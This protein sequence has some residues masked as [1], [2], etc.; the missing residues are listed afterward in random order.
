MMPNKKNIITIGVVAVLLTGFALISEA[1]PKK[2]T[3]SPN[4][5]IEKVDKQSSPTL[6][7]K[8]T[9]KKK[10]TPMLTRFP[11]LKKPE[12]KGFCCAE[13]TFYS[14]ITKT[15]CERKRGS[16]YADTEYPLK[17][18]CGWC[19]R[20]GQA[21]SVRSSSEKNKLCGDPKILY[22]SQG[23]A[24]KNCG[25]CC[26]GLRVSAVTSRSQCD[27]KR[28][29]LEKEAAEKQCKPKPVTGVCNYKDR[30]IKKISKNR[31]EKLGGKFYKRF[32]LAQNAFVETRKRIRKTDNQEK[33]VW[34]CK[35]GEVSLIAKIDCVG[36]KEKPLD[37]KFFKT[38]AEANKNCNK[39]GQR[40]RTLMGKKPPSLR[41]PDL[42]IMKISVDR[43][44]FMTV[45]VRNIG[46]RILD[47]DQHARSTI[48]L[49]AG[50]DYISRKTQLTDID[51]HGELI[52]AGG[53]ITATT[54]LRIT[55]RNQPALVWVDTN[56]Q[57][58]EPDEI[59]NGDNGPLTCKIP[60]IWCCAKQQLGLLGGKNQVGKMT[61]EECQKLGGKDMP[62]KRQ[63][64]LRVG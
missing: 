52:D 44:C 47:S 10:K 15:E 23:E 64:N 61:K 16:R 27:S 25:W 33:R 1:A 60:L 51:P 22:S 14:Q 41:P 29:H 43:R 55:Q 12:E 24:E 31:C 28:F 42:K 58:I 63:P 45:R 6:S 34:C 26:R 48:H 5:K 36:T 21:R 54:D 11:S 18:N 39:F 38:E 37:G 32:A 35:D 7:T 3:T 46:G 20:S 30:V 49:S 62:V 13:G 57:I 9:K 8:E 19:C 50:P 53:D 40:H 17:D 4:K 2:E 56:H 59:N